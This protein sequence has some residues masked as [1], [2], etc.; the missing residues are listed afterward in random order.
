MSADYI[1]IIIS[2]KQVFF[3]MYENILIIDILVHNKT[4][5][6]SRCILWENEAVCY[7]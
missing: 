7:M 4:A 2:Q 6:L 1:N 5:S 3:K